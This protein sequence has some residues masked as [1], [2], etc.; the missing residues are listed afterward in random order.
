[1]NYINILML[2]LAGLSCGKAT[3]NNDKGG[4]V[5]VQVQPA[6]IDTAYKT[7]E[8]SHYV[9][10]HSTTHVNKLLLFLGG[11][12]SVPK[13]YHLICDDAAAMGL[14]VVSLSYPNNVATAPLGTSAD[15]LV[16]DNY[17]EELCFG[18]SVSDAVTVDKL[19]CIATRATKLII[20]LKNTYPDQNWQQYLSS[21]NALLWNKIIVSGHSQGS[22]HA[23]Y[24]GKKNLVNRVVMLSGPN[25]YSI[26]Y[27]AAGHWLTEA[28]L[29]PANKQFALL[30]S[31]DEIVPYNNQITNLRGLGL[32]Q[33]AEDA[34][35]VD[36]LP[37]PYGAAHVLSLNIPAVSQHSSTV[38]NN[39]ILPAIWQYLFTAE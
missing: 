31:Q 27:G 13:D 5:A 2:C 28:G 23:G 26:Y 29:T 19:N 22:G 4:S 10:R 15:K 25:D 9:V 24:L 30:H 36:N 11:S 6:T 18:N 8:E 7:T 34:V 33:P 35:L 38:G 14:D 21:S 39:K 16:F 32:L 17:R 1:M 12:F 3:S 37:A 20:Y